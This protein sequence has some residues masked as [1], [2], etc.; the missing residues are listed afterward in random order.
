MKLKINKT[1]IETNIIRLIIWF[2]FLF[3]FSYTNAGYTELETIDITKWVFSNKEYI[4]NKWNKYYFIWNISFY[5][6]E[7][8]DTINRI[9][10]SKNINLNDIIILKN[11][12]NKSILIKWENNFSWNWCK[13]LNS[14]QNKLFRAYEDSF[15]IENYYWKMLWTA[16]NWIICYSYKDTIFMPKNSFSKYD[17]EYFIINYK[18][19][20]QYINKY[21]IKNEKDYILK[22]IYEDILLNT[23][24]NYEI[25]DFLDNL[26]E[27]MLPWRVS[28]FFSNE[29]LICDWYVKTF[30]FISRLLWIEWERIVWDIQP[31]LKTDVRIEWYLHSWVKIWDLFYDPTFD[32]DIN[33]IKFDYFWKDKI[34]FNIN[35]YIEWRYL[36]NNIDERF[37]YIKN[38]LQHIIYN[39]P[40]I[41][42]FAVKN[43]WKIIDFMNYLI[44][45]FDHNISNK[46]LCE[47]L[48]FCVWKAYSKEDLVNKIWKYYFNNLENNIIINYKL[49]DWIEIN[50]KYLLKNNESEIL[51]NINKLN[52]VEN[53]SSYIEIKYEELND[54]DIS[55][56][57]N[58]F[59]IMKENDDWTYKK[60]IE[61][62]L[63]K[64]E[65]RLN[66]KQKQILIYL[67]SLF[68]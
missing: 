60:Q 36:F 13:I 24:Y 16:N 58:M 41:T 54:N 10:Q 43:D 20:L 39:C 25:L 34:C 27:D 1:H 61:E 49:K 47:W 21:N 56:I 31:I 2:L 23:S 30:L 55:K 6:F 53:N 40:E 3:N 63:I 11:W 62:F 9:T 22:E 57:N 5:N 65:K 15:I 45:N 33:N 14:N 12:N 48:N 19:I 7:N 17:M 68:K 44:N 59:L 52:K 46:I 29:K 35:H 42:M 50:E 66:R 4:S 26:P 51:N 18:E 28:W 64:N 67:I 38:N 32:D 37:D 8:N